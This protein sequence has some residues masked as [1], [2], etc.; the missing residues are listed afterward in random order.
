MRISNNYTA[1]TKNIEFL[2]DIWLKASV[3]GSLWAAFEI[4]AGSFMHNLR[5]P[6]GGTILT[7]FVV[8]F[9]IAFAQLWP[10]RGIILRAG[11]ICAAMKSISPSA[12]LLGPM[13]GIITEAIIIEFFIALLGRNLFAYMVSGAIAV[14][15]ALLH[16]IVNMLIIYG[17]DIVKIYVNLID[18]ASSKLN[19]PISNPI[20]LI[21]LLISIYA[22]IG[23]VMATVGYLAGKKAKTLPASVDCVPLPEN[24]PD[25]KE[26]KRYSILLLFVHFF[27]IVLTLYIFNSSASFLLKLSLVIVYTLLNLIRYKSSARKLMKPFFWVQLLIVVILAALFLEKS[28]SDKFSLLN[29]FIAGM[30]LMLRAILIITSFSYISVELSNPKIR[31]YL[32]KRGF[33]KTYASL[34]LA[35]SALP[36]MIEKGSGVRRLIRN[37]FN[38]FPLVLAEAEC[39]FK[40][41][42]ADNDSR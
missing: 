24:L 30:E 23:I 5:V 40:R 19:I 17:F 2:D 16:K 21:Y 39:W 6:F 10:Q 32:I 8:L 13:I 1:E 9:L 4:I 20:N 22:A 18:Y 35:F 38:G 27:F 3:L 25:K 11:I 29:G 14:M 37:P 31:T 33:N 42:K 15:S 12:V 34:Q 36:V 28:S 7:A 41:F 26:A